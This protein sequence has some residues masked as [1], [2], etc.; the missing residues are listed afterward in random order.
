MVEVRQKIL[1][2][3]SLNEETVKQLLEKLEALG[4]QGVDDLVEVTVED[5]TPGIL[6]PIAARKLIRAWS[7]QALTPGPLS[8]TVQVHPPLSPIQPISVAL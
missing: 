6:L 7:S 4:V 2:T 8:S 1:Q 5:L 3:V